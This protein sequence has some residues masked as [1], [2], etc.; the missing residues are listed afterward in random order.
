MV[1]L[2]PMN[3]QAVR[4][5]ASGAHHT[6]ESEFAPIEHGWISQYCGRDATIGIG[7]AVA[8]I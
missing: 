2:G 6:E 3:A 7:D 5:G 1:A 8:E 4:L